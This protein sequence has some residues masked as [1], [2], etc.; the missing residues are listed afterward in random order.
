MQQGGGRPRQR[1]AIMTLLIPYGIIVVGNVLGQ[2]LAHILGILALV[3]SLVS[4]VG[5]VL[6]VYLWMQMANELK[7]VTKNPNF[8]WWPIIVPIYGIIY[9]ITQVPPEVTKAKQMVGAPEPVRP[10]VLYFF[11]PHYALASDLNDIAARMP[12]G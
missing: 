12:P 9:L 5:V 2:I 4:L 11:F 1:N 7:N 10:V 8:N 3:G 6:L